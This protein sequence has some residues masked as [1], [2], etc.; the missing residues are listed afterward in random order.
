MFCAK[1][2][3]WYGSVHKNFHANPVFIID[4]DYVSTYILHDY[5]KVSGQKSTE[6]KETKKMV[7]ETFIIQICESQSWIYYYLNLFLKAFYVLNCQ[8]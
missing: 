7:V 2:S 4:A 6:D 8:I 5:L 3:N 1:I